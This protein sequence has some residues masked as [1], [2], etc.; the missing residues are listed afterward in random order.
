M[1]DLCGFGRLPQLRTLGMSPCRRK[2]SFMG[3]CQTH[4]EAEWNYMREQLGQYATEMAAT[5]PELVA[6]WGD[7]LRVTLDGNPLGMTFL[8]YV[9][10]RLGPP[11]VVQTNT[12]AG[13]A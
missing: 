8:E 11:R 4:A 9:A 12:T 13:A 1:S 3:Y 10:S 7:Y 2:A 6:L 5:N